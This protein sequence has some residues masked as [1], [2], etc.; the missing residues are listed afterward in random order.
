MQ[1][2]AYTHSHIAA[3]FIREYKVVTHTHRA[4]HKIK[5]HSENIIYNIV[6]GRL[7]I[8]LDLLLLFVVEVINIAARKKKLD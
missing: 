8:S 3:Y 7:N 1:I 4:G 6:Y 2:G 5:G